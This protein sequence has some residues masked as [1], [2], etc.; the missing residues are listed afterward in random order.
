MLNYN[1]IIQKIGK[2]GKNKLPTHISSSTPQ[3]PRSSCP[4][5][6]PFEM[7]PSDIICNVYICIYVI[8]YI[9]IG[10]CHMY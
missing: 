5:W 4:D 2:K 8:I 3:H 1:K 10:Y 9:I 6:V 7:K